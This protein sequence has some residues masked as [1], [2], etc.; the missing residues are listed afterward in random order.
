MNFGKKL[1]QGFLIWIILYI[2][3]LF[4]LI[5]VP[6]TKD[7]LILV[8]GIVIVYTFSRIIVNEKNILEIGIIWFFVSLVFNLILMLLGIMPYYPLWST[9][10]IYFII[11][12]EPLIVKY[13]SR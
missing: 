8:V 2:L 3:G 13:F 9:L 12:A 10:M 7:V 11:I 6:T 1:L 4:L 5:F